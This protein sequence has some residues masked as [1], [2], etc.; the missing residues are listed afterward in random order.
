MAMRRKIQVAMLMAVL[1]L[2]G[3][4]PGF[5]EERQFIG[6][7]VKVDVENQ[8][9]ELAGNVLL[10]LSDSSRL[11]DRTGKQVELKAFA[12]SASQPPPEGRNPLTLTYYKA[13]AGKEGKLIIDWLSLAGP[14]ESK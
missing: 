9:I 7:L 5:A 14:I 12:E 6:V 4:Q 3:V 2:A 11:F 13:T 10:K 1:L 8:Q